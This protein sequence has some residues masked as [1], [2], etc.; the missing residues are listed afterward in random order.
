LDT[1]RGKDKRVIVGCII[2]GACLLI[3]GMFVPPPGKNICN[4]AG[5][6]LLVVGLVLLVLAFAGGGPVVI[7][8]A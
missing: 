4:I 5:A 2:L 7:G 6:I 1:A 3:V 8:P